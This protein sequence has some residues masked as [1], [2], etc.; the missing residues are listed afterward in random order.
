[1]MIKKETPPSRGQAASLKEYKY[2]ST[3]KRRCKADSQAMQILSY[4]IAHGGISTRQAFRDLECTRLSGRIKDLRDMGVPII[5]EW[6]QSRNG[7][8]YVIYRVEVEHD[9]R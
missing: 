4:M 3:L 5:S 1:M 2:Y 8:R 7:K 6:H 9:I